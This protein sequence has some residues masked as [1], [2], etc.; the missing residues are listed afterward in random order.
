VAFVVALAVA[1]AA[2]PLA[3]M[4]AARLGFVDP[5]G[6]H[7]VQ[8]VPVPYL[9]GVAVYLALVAGIAAS[10][11]LLLVPLGL[12]L[13]LGLADDLRPRSATFRIACA[14]VVGAAAGWVAPFPVPLGAVVTGVATVGL[15]NALNLLDG[16]DGLAAGVAL[17][18][19]AGFATIGGDGRVLALALA[20]GLAGFLVFNRPPAR[21]YLGDGGA[22]LTGTA[23]VLLAALL[24]DSDRSLAL[25]AALPLLV[26]V[27][28]LDTAVA[29]V[30]RLRAR[31]PLLTGDRGHVYDQ[32]IDRGRSAGVTTLALVTLQG[33]LALAAWGVT[34]LDA[35]WALAAS[36]VA[37]AALATAALAGGFT[38]ASASNTP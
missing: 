26:A 30:R 14:S 3:A 37:G 11:P 27:P 7:K 4:A 29:I 34:H 24:V 5:P 6:P 22:Y 9:G 21:I 19:A 12:A 35:R 15:L 13:A 25:W 17:V 32:L 38:S 2:T 20:G 28:V 8:T 36:L 10:R 18:S 31:R 23:L 1:L 16:L 33:V